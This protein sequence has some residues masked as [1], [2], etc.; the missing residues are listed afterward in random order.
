MKRVT[1]LAPS[2]T[3][4]LHVGHAYSFWFCEDWARRHGAKIRLRIEDIDHTRCR[5]EFTEGILEDLSWLGIRWDGAV[6]RQ[7]E[8]LDEYRA[9]IDRLRELGVI[10]PCFC[11]RRDVQREIERMGL[12]PHA[13]GPVYPGTCRGLSRHEAS[14][15]MRKE[16]FA[17][18][19]N[20]ARALELTGPITWIDAEG[21]HHPVR[22][23]HDE[24]IGR[25]D[26]GFS[27]HLAVVVDDARQGVTHVI[28]GRDLQASTPLHR[29]LQ[30]LLGLPSPV[31][32]HHPLLRDAS[33]RRLAKRDGST[34]LASL[35]QAGVRPERLR[36]WLFAEAQPPAWPEGDARKALIRELGK[37]G[38]GSPAE[39]T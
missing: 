21:R 25:K 24:I 36:A 22:P 7:S 30:A 2:P 9:A 14:R 19:L 37:A 1:R 20:C 15:R 13:A 16:L 12:A 39:T 35:R 27:Y 18:R 3:G 17:W 6:E 38:F 32:H 33:G 23:G 31:Y 4:R 11:T 8:H 5:E 34:T 28:R 26:I 29:L 10:Y